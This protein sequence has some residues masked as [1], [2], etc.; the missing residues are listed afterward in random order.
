MACR[1]NWSELARV[2]SHLVVPLDR[3]ELLLVGITSAE[4]V[5][6]VPI[7]D[8]DLS[9]PSVP[10]PKCVREIAKQALVI[11]IELPDSGRE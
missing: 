10:V 9:V 11:D 2:G 5:A 6:L 4:L 3:R 7:L 1:Q 8:R